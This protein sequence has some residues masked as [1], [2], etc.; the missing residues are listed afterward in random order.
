VV[1]HEG[2]RYVAVGGWNTL[3][4][5]GLFVLGHVLFGDSV[6]YL[7]VLTV[8]TV[9][10]VLQAYVCYRLLVF[11]REGS[12]WR[13]STVYVVA[14]AA[15]VVLLPLFVD[16]F[17]LPLLVAQAIVVAGTV[18]ASYFAHRTFSFGKRGTLDDGFA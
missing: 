1:Q 8:A 18:V 2:A 16:G 15:N 3:V 6:H 9:L 13:F 5:Y 10:A 11:R 14:Y 17:G 7:V 12:L 4:G